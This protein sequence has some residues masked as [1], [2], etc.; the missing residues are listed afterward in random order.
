ML[1]IIILFKKNTEPL[2]DYFKCNFI[3]EIGFKSPAKQHSPHALSEEQSTM[4]ELNVLGYN[5][6]TLSVIIHCLKIATVFVCLAVIYFF[7]N[8]CIHT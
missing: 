3:K 8:I 4:S 7:V 1:H 5:G 6:A 2:Y